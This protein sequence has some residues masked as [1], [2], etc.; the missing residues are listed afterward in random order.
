M[1]HRHFTSIVMSANGGLGRERLHLFLRETISAHC[2]KKDENYSVVIAWVRRKIIYSLT[3]AIISC[4]SESRTF[5]NNDEII[6][7]SLAESTKTS[8]LLSEMNIEIFTDAN[9]NIYPL[10]RSMLEELR[11]C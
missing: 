10:H 5:V 7:R 8:K 1:D 3:N 9:S 6:K 2:G 4:I 11:Q